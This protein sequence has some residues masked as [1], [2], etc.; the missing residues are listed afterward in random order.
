MH[1]RV[2]QDRLTRSAWL[3]HGLRTLARQGADALKVG[4]L[5]TALN[6]SRGSFYWHF[7]DI[8]DFRTQ[9][10]QSWQELAGLLGRD[11][12]RWSLARRG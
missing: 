8:A 11:L 6:V 4:P 3:D 2:T 5:A 10:L 7:K 1:E 12:V 9:L